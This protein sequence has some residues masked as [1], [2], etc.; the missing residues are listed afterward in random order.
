MPKVA[1]IYHNYRKAILCSSANSFVLSLQLF[2]FLLFNFTWQ[3]VNRYIRIFF[4]VTKFFSFFFIALDG[5]LVFF[6]I[7][8]YLSF[9]F[10]FFSVFN[11]F[12]SLLIN[13]MELI[14]PRRVQDSSRLLGTLKNLSLFSHAEELYFQNL[15]PISP[16]GKQRC[17]VKLFN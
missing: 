14:L 11:I 9:V 12:N 8:S 6:R 13:I 16:E 1:I 3:I 2:D 17:M 10:M 7:F 15:Q 4:P 5:T